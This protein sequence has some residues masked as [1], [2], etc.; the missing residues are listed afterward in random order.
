M[1]LPKVIQLRQMLADK[2]PGLRL[3]LDKNPACAI[4]Q[5][6]ALPPLRAIWKWSGAMEL[7]ELH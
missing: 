2:F 1:P 3:H 7:M 4:G 6:K 5:P